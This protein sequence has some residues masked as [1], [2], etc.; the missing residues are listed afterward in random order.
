[1][2]WNVNGRLN[3]A[4]LI[5]RVERLEAEFA[6]T[7]RCAQKVVYR[8]WFRGEQP[9]AGPIITMEINGIRL[10][11]PRTA[12]DRGTAPVTPSENSPT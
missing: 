2:A 8:L 4:G 7:A 3:R 1:M 5:H 12:R 6:R 10:W 9:P 11:R